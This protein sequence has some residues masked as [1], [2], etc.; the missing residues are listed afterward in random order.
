MGSAANSAWILCLSPTSAPGFLRGIRLFMGSVYR[1]LLFLHAL[2]FGSAALD[3]LEQF[4]EVVLEVGEDL[5]G[6]VLGAEADLAL[7]AAGVLHDLGAPLLGAPG[8]LLLGG[9]LLGLV[10]GAADDAVGLGA[11]LVQHG[12]ALLD[13]PSRLFELLWDRLTHLVYNVEGGVAVYHRRVAEA[14]EAPGVLDQLFQPVYEY[15][16]VHLRQPRPLLTIP[17]SY[18][19]SRNKSA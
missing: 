6:V 11:G 1:L 8:D 18:R 2:Q 17:V 14:G 4:P 13:D 7:A 5:V 9:D 16:Y 3:G 15:Q 12:L 19:P 10:L